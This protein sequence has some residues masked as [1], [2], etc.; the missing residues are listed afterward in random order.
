VTPATLNIAADTATRHTAGGAVLVLL[1]LAAVAAYVVSLYLWPWR[2]C[3]RCG[4]T[5]TRRGS[6]AR[7]FGPC[8]RCRGT[9]HTQRRGSRT[10][11]RAVLAARTEMARERQRRRDQKAADTAGDPR[12]QENRPR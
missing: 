10:V 12:E 2:N 8:R 1:A 5:G 11:A 3:P 6:N 4:G 7:R 9:R